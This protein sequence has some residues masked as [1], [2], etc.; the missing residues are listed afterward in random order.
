[1]RNDST[2]ITYPVAKSKQANN[3]KPE[4]VG[5]RVPRVATLSKMRNFQQKIMRC[6]K[7]Q[8]ILI[9]TP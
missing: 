8:K 9:H 7:K 4:V 2:N 3:I 5:A 1:M 6:T